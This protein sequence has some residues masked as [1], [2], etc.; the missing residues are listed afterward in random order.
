MAFASGHDVSEPL[1]RTFPGSTYLGGGGGRRNTMSTLHSARRLTGYAIQAADGVIGK[2]REFYFDDAT[3]AVRYFVVDVRRWLLHRNVLLSPR[4][5]G[6]P[7]DGRRIVPASVTMGQVRRS[8]RIDTDKP[9][10]L[11][12]Q[13]QLHKHYGWE[14][15]WGAEA[16]IGDAAPQVFSPM[17]PANANGAPFDPHLRTTRVVTGHDVL[18]TDGIAGKV[19]DFLLD[20]ASWSIGYLVVLLEEGRRVALPTLWIRQIRLETSRVYVDVP[21]E[22]IRGCLPAAL[23]AEDQ[24]PAFAT[25]SAGDRPVAGSRFP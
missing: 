2:I 18:A 1:R 20:E 13:A 8:P 24:G 17:E 14:F 5:M 16:V 11:Q 21:V 4:V 12:L 19:D 15:Y 6:R 25:A 3:W 10:A 9:I 23:P 22:T 7:D